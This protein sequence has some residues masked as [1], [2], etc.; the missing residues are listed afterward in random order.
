MVMMKK[1]G[2][3]NQKQDSITRILM[4]VLMPIPCQYQVPSAK[5]L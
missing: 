1:T 3:M 2:R 5:F 4:R